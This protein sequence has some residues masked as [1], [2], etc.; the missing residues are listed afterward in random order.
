MPTVNPNLLVWARE[1]AGQSLAEA[2]HALNIRVEKLSSLESGE[3]TPARSTLLKM[4]KE[5]RR[6]LLTFYLA[7]PP[8]RGDRGQDFRTLPAD[9]SIAGDALLDALIR[10]LVA[11]QSIVRSVLEAE[12]EIE[13]VAMVG[14]IQIQG[15][16]E[17]A[18]A[19]LR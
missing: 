7:H 1:S 16:I 10:D 17:R 2:A 4:S 12:D 14:S 6:S 11:R 8:A 13:P 3:G 15:G 18:V 19:P 5:Y 9:R